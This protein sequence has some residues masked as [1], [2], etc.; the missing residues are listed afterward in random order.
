[1]ISWRRW[2]VS[3]VLPGAS[4]LMF[5]AALCLGSQPLQAGTIIVQP[6]Q[7]CDY[8]GNNCGDPS[9]QLYAAATNKIWAQAG[10]SIDF[11]TWETAD[12]LADG[13][14][15]DVNSG[16][17]LNDLFNPGLNSSL[18]SSYPAYAGNLVISMWFVGAINYCGT[19]GSAYGCSE[20]PGHE[21]VIANN[22]FDAGRLDTIAH[23][24]GHNLGLSHC[25]D[26]PA[27]CG[28]A[29]P[30][31]LMD[32]GGDRDAPTSIDQITPTGQLDQLSSTEIGIAQDSPLDVPE[33]GTVLL[34]GIGILGLM[35][36]RAARRRSRACPARVG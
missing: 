15:L 4:S 21:V 31:W 1:M 5:A 29:S 8:S 34:T 28:A 26:V 23:E 3:G 20:E 33:P 19:N 25:E 24:I 36:G 30:Y 14:P 17:I 35:G 13:A 32:A 18:F 7:V 12:T 27:Q 22:V 16:A 2:G 11:L 10:I 9:Q 6:I